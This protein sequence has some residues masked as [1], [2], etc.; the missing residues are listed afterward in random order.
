MPAAYHP[1]MTGFPDQGLDPGAVLDEMRRRKEGDADWRS[2][3]T[4][5]LVYK[6]DDDEVTRVL[7]EAYDLYLYEN[8]L[9]PFAFPSLAGYENEVVTWV[10]DLLHGPDS[11]A[12]TM[13]SGGTESIFLAVQVARDRAREEQGVERAEVV[14]PLSAHPA[15]DKAAH[16][17]G[18]ELRKAPLGDD[19]RADPGA[20]AE[21]V[22]ESTAL[23]VGSAPCYPFGVVDPIPEIA[24][25]AAERGIPCHVDA[26]LGGFVL[27]FWERLGEPVPPWDFRVDG[28]TSISADVHKYGYAVKGASTLVHRTGDGLRYQTFFVTDWVGGIYGSRTTAGTRPAGP[29]A[30]AWAIMRHLGAD[31]YERLTAVVRDTTRQLRSGI[32]AI[33]GLHVLGEPDASTF[34]FA[35]D[36]HD[37]VAD[38]VDIDAVA[39]VMD[40]AGWRLDRQP[41]SLHV[42][43]MPQHAP[44]ADAFLAD[45]ARAV[46][47]HGESRG[48]E[49]RYA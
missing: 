45:L 4:W 5:S 22:T 47:T 32:E 15:F 13:S 40:D 24:G 46:E 6:A 27:P 37:A 3:R 16:Y 42:I 29:I 34:A 36:D 2:G 18:I 7:E 30:A 21:L 41:G 28:V 39:D 10:A 48:K 9:N 31:G 25:L 38:P 23:L 26:C 17:L 14:V 44:V 8:A 49:A 11:A 20:M 35:A 1:G 12:G 33:D 19:L 43:V